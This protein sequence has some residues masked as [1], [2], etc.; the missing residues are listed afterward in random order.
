MKY[1]EG[2]K[3]YY[4]NPFVFFIDFVKIEM[5]LVENNELFY[6][7]SVGAYLREPDLFEDLKEAQREA[8]DRLEKYCCEMRY[9]ILNDKPKLEE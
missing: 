8:L 9:R 7:D 5:G 6:I 3:L 2:D 4:V 1:K